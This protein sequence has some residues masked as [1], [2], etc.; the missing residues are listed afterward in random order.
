VE[1]F[2]LSPAE[3]ETVYRFN[4]DS[5]LDEKREKFVMSEIQDDVEG[6]VWWWKW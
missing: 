6:E 2:L 5:L 4:R 1:K 3:A